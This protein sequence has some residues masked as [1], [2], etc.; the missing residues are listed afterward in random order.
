M[1]AAISRSPMRAARSSS[2]TMPVSLSPSTIG[3]R[4]TPLSTISLVA[5]VTSMP[6]APVT[7]GLEAWPPAGASP[8]WPS[9]STLTARSRSVMKPIGSPASSTSTTDP[10]LRSRMSSATWR[11]GASGVAVTTDSVMTSRISMATGT[12]P[13]RCG[14]ARP[15]QSRRGAAHIHAAR[16]A[17]A[18]R[19]RPAHRGA[20]PRPAARRRRPA[21]ARGRPRRARS[22]ASGPRGDADLGPAARRPRDGC[23]TPE[24]ALAWEA[25]HRQRAGI[26]ALIAAVC[27]FLGVILT[28]VGQPSANK[29]D[30]KILTV[31]DTMRNTAAGTPNPPGRVSAYTVDVGQNPAL[32]ITGAILYGI[33]SLAI[34]FALAYLF[35]AT[36][37]RKPELPQ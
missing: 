35:R 14:R 7:T 23:M 24:E 9:A 28:T 2:V 16:L 15:I 27:T 20:V 30:D 1:L 29:F 19:S 8:S 4:R 5:S 32:P 34:F 31:V 25:E 22:A 36:R 17:R 12:L 6:G 21:V 11:T 26:A 18:H 10:T 37:A 13:P 3:S 33:G